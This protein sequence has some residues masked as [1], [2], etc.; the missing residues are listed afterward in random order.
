MKALRIAD[1]LFRMLHQNQ[2]YHSESNGILLLSCGGLGD[3]ILFSHVLERYCQLAKSGETVTVLLRQDGAKTAFLFSSSVEK[4]VVDFNKLRTNLIY[5]WQVM[6]KINKSHYRLVITTD[7]VRH[8]DLD[9]AIMLSAN[10]QQTIAMKA[11]SWTKYDQLLERNRQL[12]TR[13]FDSGPALQDKV[14]RWTAF[15]NWLTGSSTPPPLVGPSDNLSPDTKPGTP[16]ILIQPF[17]AVKAKQCLPAVYHKIIQSLSE[18][19]TFRIT[20]TLGDLENNPEFKSLNELPN[21]SFDNSTFVELAE[22]MKQ[23]SLVISVDTAAMHLAVSVGVQTLCLASAAYV[24]EIT[25]YAPE[26]SPDHAHFL[27]QPME[28]QGC[29][30]DCSKPLQQGQ[31]PCIAMLDEQTIVDKVKQLMVSS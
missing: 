4:L 1:S 24:G 23:A 22:L 6:K 5:R 27:Y 10:A 26:I 28:C 17:S 11:R 9:E 16:L 19:T 21:V 8:P 13:I 29:L 14:V 12:F 2:P 15:A 25:P 31:F 3:T 20:G 18:E 7:Y 30:G